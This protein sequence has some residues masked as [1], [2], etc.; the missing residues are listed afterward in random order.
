MNKLNITIGIVL[1]LCFSHPASSNQ[2]MV[3]K[4]L[5]PTIFSN[6][7]SF[8]EDEVRIR[9]ESM[10][11]LVDP[12]IEDDVLDQVRRF[13]G[14]NKN[15]ALEILKRTEIYFPL[16][17]KIFLEYDLPLELK[18]L[19]IVE[20][21]L[22]LTAKSNVGAAGI[23]QLMPG[24]ARILKLRV[25][26]KLDQRLDPYL[27]THAAA[28][29]FK[30]LY[31]MFNDWSLVLAAYNCGENRVKDLVASTGAKDFWEIKKF[32]PRQTQLFV[33]AFIG[34]SYMMHYHPDHDI[35]PAKV[36]P[37]TEKITFA[38]IYKEVHL[39]DLFKKT[40]ISKELF[41]SLNPSFKRGVIPAMR[42]GSSISLPDSL[43]V[44]FVDYYMF[45]N[46]KNNILAEARIMLQDG[47]PLDHEI[48][49]FNRP[50]I[51]APDNLT[52]RPVDELQIEKIPTQLQLL[53]KLPALKVESAEDFR[54]HVVR[55][56]ESFSEIADSYQVD[57]EDLISWN[58][59]DP[60]QSLR[61]G[62]VLR[63]RR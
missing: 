10:E 4:D 18:Y 38:K 62:T 39:R 1:M 58:E 36:F 24:T 52:S 31:G 16:I 50:F 2:S 19:T 12:K 17:D 23:W 43:M 3:F 32:L 60:N 48:I 33:P 14:R 28:R 42:S 13:V 57:V 7:P 21:S 61:T 46:S 34:A 30:T 35:V 40:G 54:Y 9:L 15:T 49:S 26:E 37:E 11:C 6:T 47:A 22:L 45:Q 5:W 8:Y 55:S 29:Y 25:D 51:F 63:V 56:R 41:M 27:A 20:S 53:K 44:E 59:V